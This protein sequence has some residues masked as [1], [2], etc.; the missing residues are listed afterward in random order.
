MRSKDF[1]RAGEAAKCWKVLE[2][3]FQKV[4]DDTAK[5]DQN[6]ASL[7]LSKQFKTAKIAE[8]VAEYQRGV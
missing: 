2:K 7:L 6:L 1:R 5:A 8:S 4:L 3:N